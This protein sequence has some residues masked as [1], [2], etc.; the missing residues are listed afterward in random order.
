MRVLARAKAK[1]HA[2]KLQVRSMPRSVQNETT[3]LREVCVHRESKNTHM[4]TH[5]TCVL[6]NWAQHIVCSQ[7]IVATWTAPWNGEQLTEYQG[8]GNNNHHL[9][10]RPKAP[11]ERTFGSSLS[12]EISNNFV[13]AQLPQL[14]MEINQAHC[15][16]SV[17]SWKR[18]RSIHTLARR[19]DGA[20]RRQCVTWSWCT[21]PQRASS[22]RS[23]QFAAVFS[24]G[25][26]LPSACGAAGASLFIGVKLWL[27]T[28]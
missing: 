28:F 8:M 7:S 6:N 13:S 25:R 9:A 10:R 27:W 15:R 4:S 21:S 22:V 26:Q 12:G 3:R 11:R 17:G 16:K 14:S 24:R 18:S 2:V 19:C 23:E 20:S 1:S 5:G